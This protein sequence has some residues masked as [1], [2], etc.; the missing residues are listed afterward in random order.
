[1]NYKKLVAATIGLTVCAFTGSNAMAHGGGGGGHGGGGFGGGGFHAGG[2]GGGGFR[3]GGF[4]S[5][6]NSGGF[7]GGG[8]RSGFIG[9]GFRNHGF[10]GDRFRHRDFDD[11]FFL[12]GDFGDPFFYYPY[13]YYGY[14]PYGSYPYDYG[15]GSYDSYNQPVYQSSARYTDSVI[16]EV[17]LRLARGGYYHGAIDGVS[18]SETRRAIRAYEHA[19]AL[20]QDGRIG[21]R[22]LTTMG[23]S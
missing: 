8:F 5:A 6:F 16:G 3:G 21:E 7:R 11:R 4:R 18:G 23:L 22:L 1:M 2:F 14:Y 10:G 9:N 17:Q 15:Y 13:P 20:P 19:H 12:F